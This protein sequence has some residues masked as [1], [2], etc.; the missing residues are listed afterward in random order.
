MS[1]LIREIS[2]TNQMRKEDLQSAEVARN[3]PLRFASFSSRLLLQCMRKFLWGNRSQ[4]QDRIWHALKKKTCKQTYKNDPFAMFRLLLQRQDGVKVAD[5]S[6]SIPFDIWHLTT[7]GKKR[8]MRRRG[9][10][11]PPCDCST[12]TGRICRYHLF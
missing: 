8:H 11:R 3:V 9:P 4:T 7:E 2:R 6:A 12:S 5:A 10:P 1:W